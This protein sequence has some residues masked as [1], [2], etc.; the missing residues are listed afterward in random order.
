MNFQEA[1][2]RLS[3]TLGKE[4]IRISSYQ[5]RMHKKNARGIR[6]KEYEKSVED[7]IQQVRIDL[8]PVIIV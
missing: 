5:D 7:A 6:R 1:S 3:Y 4:I 8:S 2:S